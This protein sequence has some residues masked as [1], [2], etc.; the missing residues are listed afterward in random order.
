MVF[1]WPFFWQSLFHPSGAYLGGLGLTVV[2]SILS[3]VLG[4]ILGLVIAL[5]R[6][7]KNVVLRSLAAVYVWVMQGVP[8]LVVLVVIYLGLAAANVYRF[9]DSSLMGISV[10]GSVQAA[11]VGL[12]LNNAAYISEIIRSS[13]VAVPE[14]QEEAATTLGMTKLSSMRWIILPQAVRTMIP[15]LGNQFNTL[16]KNTSLLSIIGVTEIFLVTQA[17]S[18]ATFHT[19]EIFIVTGIYYLALT[20]CWTVLQSELERLASRRL[21]I[22]VTGPFHGLIAGW[23]AL[24]R[25]NAAIEA[26]KAETS[27]TV[28]DKPV[29]EPAT[30]SLTATVP[31]LAAEA[32]VR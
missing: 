9:R 25:R 6:L 29:V 28:A 8:L 7:S 14:G 15:P 13:I 11:I 30:E 3:M 16:M 10:A 31:V 26:T 24:V 27:A 1:N 4:V 22:E 18:S 12:T 21:G 32:T 2:V 17:V 23:Q 5:A 19:F 20:T